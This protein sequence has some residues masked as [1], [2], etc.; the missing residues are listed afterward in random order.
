[1]KTLDKIGARKLR[2]DRV[3]VVRTKGDEALVEIVYYDAGD[4]ITVQTY[5]LLH[6][7]EDTWK[8]FLVAANPELINPNYAAERCK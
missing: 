6:R 4:N 8:V 3:R 1:M 2:L 5:A 7:E